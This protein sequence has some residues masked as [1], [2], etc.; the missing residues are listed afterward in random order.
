ME[1]NIQ[2]RCKDLIE[3]GWDM[4]KIMEVERLSFDDWFDLFP[5]K[6]PLLVYWRLELDD[7]TKPLQ[8]EGAFIKLIEVNDME[9]I[10]VYQILNARNPRITTLIVRDEFSHFFLPEDTSVG[11]VLLSINRGEKINYILG[12]L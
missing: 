11:K 10:G 6:P 1:R 7:P 2:K 8:D 4:K 5:K 12:L 9:K 3:A